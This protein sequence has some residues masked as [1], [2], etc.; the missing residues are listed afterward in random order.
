MIRPTI[1]RPIPTTTIPSEDPKIISANLPPVYAINPST[2]SKAGNPYAKTL[3]IIPIATSIHLQ[4]FECF[5]LL[6]ILWASLSSKAQLLGCV[7][8]TP[9]GDAQPTFYGGAMQ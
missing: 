6:K 7:F 4:H 9:D 1:I 8:D 5:N 3:T 2:I